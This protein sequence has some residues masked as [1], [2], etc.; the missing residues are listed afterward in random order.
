MEEPN[1]EIHYG[2]NLKQELKSTEAEIR[3]A[4][5]NRLDQAIINELKVKALRI[6]DILDQNRLD[7]EKDEA[8]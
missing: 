3:S 8:A 6:R 5:D 1:H 4:Q 7:E 2:D